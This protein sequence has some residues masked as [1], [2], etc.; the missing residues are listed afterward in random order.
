MRTVICETERLSLCSVTME[1]AE[2][3][4]RLT[5]DPETARYIGGA[6]TLEWHVQRTKEII[7]HQQVHGF[8]R[9]TVVLKSNAEQVGR[10]GLL[11]KE[12]E[13]IDEVELGYFFGRPHWGKGYATEAARAVLA[14]GVNLGQ[15][16]MVAIIDPE[17]SPSI[18]VAEKI[19]MRF[20]RM[21]QWEGGTATLYATESKLN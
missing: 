2:V 4:F 6:R 3:A 1:D 12:I 15:R 20:E 14:H 5:T 11:W 21:I 19:G 17:N 7:Q 8:A 18:H 16:R 10:C 13:A 9:F